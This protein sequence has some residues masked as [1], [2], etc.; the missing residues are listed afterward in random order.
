MS[1]AEEE[2]IRR[3]FTDAV[4]NR[5]LLEHARIINIPSEHRKDYKLLLQEI[6]GWLKYDNPDDK[7]PLTWPTSVGGTSQ[8]FGIRVKISYAFWNWFRTTGIRNLR[9]HNQEHG[10]SIRIIQE[11][12]LRNKNRESLCLYVR[13]YIRGLYA[14]LGKKPVE[15]RLKKDRLQIGDTG[16]HDPVMLVLR[17]NVNL[18]E[19]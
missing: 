7:T 6:I 19:W 13:N 16:I 15:M 17:L 9:A 11:K 14:K 3:K 5:L 18:D 12:G 8:T 1:T 10:T 4:H 2:E